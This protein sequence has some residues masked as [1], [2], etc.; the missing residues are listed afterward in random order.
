[1]DHRFDK[2]TITQRAIEL[3]T[4]FSNIG[5]PNLGI[6]DKFNKILSHYARDL[7][8]ISKVYQ[9]N[10]TDPPVARDLPPIA[11]KYMYANIFPI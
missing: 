5:L 10:K 1:M 2:I 6:Q 7:D 8:M 11:G 9:K 4:R 3:L